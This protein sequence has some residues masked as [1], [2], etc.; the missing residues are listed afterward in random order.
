MVAAECIVDWYSRT[1]GDDVKLAK[2]EQISAEFK[3]Q[4]SARNGGRVVSAPFQ[5]RSKGS[6]HARQT[7]TSPCGFDFG[8][9]FA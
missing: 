9:P 3:G 6:R 1:P 5:K 7:A 8:M 4:R 2:I